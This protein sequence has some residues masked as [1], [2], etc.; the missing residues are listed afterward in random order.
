[1]VKIVGT[2]LAMSTEKYIVYIV[3]NQKVGTKNATLYIAETV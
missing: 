3:K 1:M 2:K